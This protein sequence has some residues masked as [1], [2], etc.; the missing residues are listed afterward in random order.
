MA[1]ATEAIK[2]QS[3]N[4]D[5]IETSNLTVAAGVTIYEGTLVSIDA[6]GNAIVGV[7]GS[8]LA[9]I[10]ADTREAGESLTCRSGYTVRFLMAT[11]A[12][13]DM[14][15]AAYAADNQTATLTPG[16]AILGRIVDV[17]VGEAIWVKMT[18]RA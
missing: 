3:R 5:Q 7:S 18:L 4:N 12:L 13:T 2:V 11:A 10:A 14:N 8:R 17:E 6:S 9:G 15:K 16:T 1:A